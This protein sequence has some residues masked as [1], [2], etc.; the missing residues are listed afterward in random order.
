VIHRITHAPFDVLGARFTPVRLKHGPR[1]DVLG[2]RVGNVAY[3]TDT[4]EIPE[5][6]W[7]LLEGLDVL[8]LDALRDRPHAT[9]FSLEQ[10]IAVARK[11]RAKRTLFTHISHELDHARTNSRLPAGMEL[12]YDGQSVPL[13]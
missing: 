7:R 12:A 4:N 8:V 6:S 11:L 1:F 9:H 5:T 2:F 10:A 3:C 13:T